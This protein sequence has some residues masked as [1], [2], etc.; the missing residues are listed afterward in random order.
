MGSRRW[1]GDFC[2]PRVSIG[3]IRI[4][5]YYYVLRRCSPAAS[6]SREWFHDNFALLQRV[7][8]CLLRMFVIVAES[9][10][11]FGAAISVFL[12]DSVSSFAVLW[13]TSGLAPVEFITDQWQVFQ[14]RIFKAKP[15]KTRISNWIC[16]NQYSV[17]VGMSFGGTTTIIGYSPESLLCVLN[18]TSAFIADPFSRIFQVNFA[19]M[20]Q[21][22]GFHCQKMAQMSRNIS[23]RKYWK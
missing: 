18:K 17:A 3:V 15:R 12:V 10:L 4:V 19:F 16:I 6:H 13:S 9:A 2:L 22:S 8:I 23:L 21:V 1:G 11:V 14:D 7:F 5:V 20:F